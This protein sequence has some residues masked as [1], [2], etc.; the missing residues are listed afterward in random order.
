[1][2][3]DDC[4]GCSIAGTT[5]DAKK[6]PDPDLLFQR[7]L[8]SVSSLDS[9]TTMED[10]VSHELYPYSLLIFEESG[11]IRSTKKSELVNIV[12]GSLSTKT[13]RFSSNFM[14]L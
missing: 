13:D 5:R 7:E 8:A 9:S 6:V 1:M 4:E 2:H 12:I 14:K 3:S 10:I 11:M